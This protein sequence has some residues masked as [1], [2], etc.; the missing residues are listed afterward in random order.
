MAWQV[1]GG[2][3]GD[4]DAEGGV[5]VPHLHVGYEP[6]RE[7]IVAGPFERLALG[8]E[9]ILVALRPADRLRRRLGLRGEARGRQRKPDRAGG[10]EA[11]GKK[12]PTVVTDGTHGNVLLQRTLSSRSGAPA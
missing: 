11:V 7:R 4:A 5:V 9:G 12:L 8:D 10:A 6:D 3:G 2:I 1:I